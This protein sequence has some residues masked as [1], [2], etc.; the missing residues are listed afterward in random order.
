MNFICF[1]CGFTDNNFH[2]LCPSC[3]KNYNQPVV[4][5]NDGLLV[6]Y[7]NDRKGR[8]VFASKKFP[9]GSLVES[10]PVLVIPSDQAEMMINTILWQ[11][12]FPWNTY[13]DFLGDR[14]VCMGYGLLYNHSKNSNTAYVFNDNPQLKSIDFYARRDIE[15]GEEIT[16]S[17]GKILWFNDDE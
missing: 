12:L 16:I 17:Y 9:Y 11:Y 1:E 4:S 10:C 6:K 3:G 15:I 2:T 8:G 5:I 7:I 13:D 14:A